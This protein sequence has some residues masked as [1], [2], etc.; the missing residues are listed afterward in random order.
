MNARASVCV[1]RQVSVT[2][3]NVAVCLSNT[4]APPG[5]EE[6]H[7]PL[8]AQSCACTLENDLTAEKEPNG[9]FRFVSALCGFLKS[10]LLEEFE[11]PEILRSAVD[12]FWSVR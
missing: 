12:L 11:A 10:L 7:L 5:G 8:R 3:N 9:L 2:V 1:A 6:S 4:D